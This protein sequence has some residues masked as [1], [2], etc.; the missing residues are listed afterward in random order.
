MALLTDP[1]V[2]DI[3][4]GRYALNREIARG[5]G[6]AVFQAV[7]QFTKRPVAIKLL[8][9]QYLV[10]AEHRERLLREAQALTIA[11]HRNV[12]EVL[13]AGISEAGGPYL[14]MELLDGRS[15]DGLLASR[16]RL[17][18]EEAIWVAQQ[19]AAAVGRMH[20]LG[21]VHRDVKPGNAF[22]V[23]TEEGEEILK[24]L[25]YG[26]TSLSEAEEGQR[27]THQSAL[28]GTP[29]YMAPEQ[30]LGSTDPD[31]RI[32]VYALGIS[33]YE[34][35]SG[36]VPFEGTF[37]QVLLKVH[38]SHAP[39]LRENGVEVP[40]DVER[41]VARCIEKDA[42]ARFADAGKL[43]DALA[44]I[45]AKLPSP[46]ESLLGIRPAAEVTGAKGPQRRFARAPYVTPVTAIQLDGVQF[47]GRNQDLSEGG[48]LVLLPLACKP[49]L[50]TAAEFA[51]PISGRVVRVPVKGRW[52]RS[53]RMASAVGL[54][55]TQLSDAHREEIHTYV[56]SLVNK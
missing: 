46:E 25:D 16:K 21:L 44:A 34:C 17:K 2:G 43:G 23:H 27:I 3:V 52:V 32:D 51:L 41:L 5:G 31:P 37:G 14:V 36:A 20:R 38:Q 1:K 12:V 13:D 24:M 55:F 29:E 15:L 19:M 56:T 8:T 48:L 42:S 30:L 7:H 9:S 4:D 26:T 50:L 22:V 47:S 35:L 33:L 39:A 10:S 11:R 45:A 28:I 18:T 49:E 53:A 6:G 54:E 40:E